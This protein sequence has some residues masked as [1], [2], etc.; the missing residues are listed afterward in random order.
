MSKPQIF[1][2]TLAIA[3]AATLITLAVSARPCEACLACYRSPDWLAAESPLVLIGEVADVKEPRK[4]HA[5]Q[6]SLWGSDDLAKPSTAVVRVLTVLKGTCKEEKLEIGS[7]PVPSCAGAFHYGFE[8]GDTRIFML[9]ALPVK[10]YAALAEQG[11]LRDLSQREMIENRILRAAEFKRA[12]LAE[13]GRETPDVAAAAERICK[14]L[15]TLVNAWPEQRLAKSEDYP[16][17]Y[18]E[19]T[20]DVEKAV[21]EVAKGLAGEK[22]ETLRTALA[23]VWSD[24][25]ADWPRHNVWHKALR[26][27][28]DRRADDIAVSRLAYYKRV[29]TQ[30]GVDASYVETYLKS[31]K[32]ADMRSQLDFPVPNPNPYGHELEGDILTTDF[33]LRFSSCLRGDMFQDYG[34]QSEQLASL[35]P[36]RLKPVLPAICGSDDGRLAR[37]GYWAIEHMPGNDYVR[38]MLDDVLNGK[39]EA[40]Q[41]L[42]GRDH[43]GSATRRLRFLVSLARKELPPQG[44]ERFWEQVARGGCFNPAVVEGAMDHLEQLEK[45]RARNVKQTKEGRQPDTR[46]IDA[47]MEGVRFFLEAALKA[48]PREERSVNA[49][50]AAEYKE[51][52]KKAGVL[53]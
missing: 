47:A 48:G 16:E 52:L 43:R 7:G 13:V 34:M 24:G 44:L 14:R 25:A 23:M 1:S 32:P 46:R 50:S 51:R 22:I 27:L 40:W 33:I 20:E 36:A 29:L 4:G 39:T 2:R 21:E 31:L 49:I 19:D 53:K 10:G 9:P 35:K 41:Y 26:L 15:A 5:Q 38:I 11:S 6:E 3:T 12:Y 8:K 37:V 18:L 45:D 42:A 28:S 30:A 17:G